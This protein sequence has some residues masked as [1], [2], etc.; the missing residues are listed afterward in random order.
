[1]DEQFEQKILLES[2][3]V[4]KMLDIKDNTN[5]LRKCGTCELYENIDYFDDNNL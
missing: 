5:L 2:D 3:D 1:M 4:M